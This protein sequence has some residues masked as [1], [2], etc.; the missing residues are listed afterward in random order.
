MPRAEA[1]RI[2]FT[3]IVQERRV[4]RQPHQLDANKRYVHLLNS[5]TVRTPGLDISCRQPSGSMQAFAR[6]SMGK[7]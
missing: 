1:L 2:L 6:I 4:T 7:P 5:N 3:K